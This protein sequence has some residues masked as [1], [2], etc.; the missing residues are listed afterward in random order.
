[1]NLLIAFSAL[2]PSASIMQYNNYIYF[3]WVNGFINKQKSNF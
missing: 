3:N 1:M 2:K